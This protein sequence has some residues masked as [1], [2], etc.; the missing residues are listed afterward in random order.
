MDDMKRD[1]KV[2]AAVVLRDSNGRVLM[3]RQNY[4]RRLWSLPGGAMEF[5][6][7]PADAAVREAREELGIVVSV[8][9]LVGVY[10]NATNPGVINNFVFHAVRDGDEAI[11]I[12]EVEL[13]CFDWFSLD[14]LPE[15]CT[16]SA[17]LAIRDALDG[18]A[19]MYREIR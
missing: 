11:A 6:E 14:S 2:A 15:N 1:L 4:G 9:A 10:V 7:T 8:G 13:S 12:D 5:G 19:G 16:A 17:P 18:T 3:V